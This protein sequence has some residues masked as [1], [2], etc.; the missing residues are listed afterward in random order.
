MRPSSGLTYRLVDRL[1]GRVE[2]N[3]VFFKARGLAHGP[4]L[5]GPRVGGPDRLRGGGGGG[6]GGSD[7]PRAGEPN[8]PRVDGPNWRR[9]GGLDKLNN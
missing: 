6:G 9:A 2:S 3:F 7:G 8:M 4:V 5:G 1:M